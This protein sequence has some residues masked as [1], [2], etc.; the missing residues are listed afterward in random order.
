MKSVPLLLALLLV[1]KATVLGAVSIGDINKG[2]LT[3]DP[4][5]AFNGGRATV[6]IN[7]GDF[8]KMQG[9]GGRVEMQSVST[10]D[11]SFD[12]KVIYTGELPLAD[13]Y[14]ISPDDVMTITATA[15]HDNLTD[16]AVGLIKY[17]DNGKLT[18]RVVSVNAVPEPATI[19]LMLGLVALSYI[20]IKRRSA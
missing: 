15:R 4:K 7:N 8:F 2:L 6:R 14:N 1:S 17:F 10:K 12:N 5:V 3:N 11:W 19:A 20:A 16:Y 9:F 13:I 18:L